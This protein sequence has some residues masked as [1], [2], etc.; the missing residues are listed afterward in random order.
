MFKNAQAFSSFSVDDIEKAK[1]FYSKILGLDISEE[2]HGYLWL[3]TGGD[4][5]TFIYQKDN[6][7]PATFTILNLLVDDIDKAADELTKRGV[8][9]EHY[10][11][12]ME[13]DAKGIF[14]GARREMGPNIAW[15]KDPAGNILSILESE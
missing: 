11:G 12:E 15:F 1:A 7:E 6:H 10:K 13:T 5:K 4:Q 14:R 2:E 9:F 3:H 8:N